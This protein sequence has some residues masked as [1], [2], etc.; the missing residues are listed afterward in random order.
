MRIT[1]FG[2]VVFL[3]WV[4]YP[5]LLLVN[6]YIQTAVDDFPSLERL[7]FNDMF[8]FQYWRGLDANCIMLL[9]EFKLINCPAII[10]FPSAHESLPNLPI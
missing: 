2:S 8:E 1:R 6:I 5:F 9:R 7:E 10:N 3:E 4:G